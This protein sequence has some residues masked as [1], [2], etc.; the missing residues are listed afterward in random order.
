[1]ENYKKSADFFDELSIGDLELPMC[2]QHVLIDYSVTIP[3]CA[4]I[5]VREILRISSTFIK[6]QN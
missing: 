5:K 1:M 2:H 3:E 4:K 6:L